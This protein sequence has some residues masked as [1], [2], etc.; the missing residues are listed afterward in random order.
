MWMAA[1]VM[2]GLAGD[3]DVLP[4]LWIVGDS[5]VKNGSGKGENGQ[6]GWGD[7]L[8]PHFDLSRIAIMNRA[9]GG[10]SSRTFLT[11]GRWDAILQEA[12]SGDFLLI[13]FGHNDP[14]PINDQ[15][16]ARGTIPGIG[17][18]VVEIDNLL[19]KKKETV[20]T[21]GWYLRKYVRDAKDKG[22]QPILC[23]YIPRCPRPG[24]P[25]PL[26]AEAASYR[27]WTKQVAEQEKVP[28]LDL[29]GLI[30]AEYLGMTQEEIKTRYFCKEDFTHTNQEG[31]ERNAHHL[32]EGLRAFRHP[33]AA[34]LRDPAS[35]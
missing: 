26:K 3:P 13:Q 8:G 10:R 16:R 6:W 23:T 32:V 28:C 4:R 19:T 1:V 7:K 12:R 11:D 29:F 25:W 17:E 34:L 15:T 35:P 18:E 33:L 20:R 30:E 14:A 24:H 21:F 27:H 22:V 5:T 9:I 2:G 31:A